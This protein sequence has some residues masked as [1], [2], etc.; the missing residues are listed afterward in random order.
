MKIAAVVGLTTAL[1]MA[2]APAASAAPALPDFDAFP[3]ADA[4]DYEV[5]GGPVYSVRGFRTPSGIYCTSSSHRG[6]SALDC[7]GPFV[8]APDDANTAHF[9][10][11]FDGAPSLAF[12]K[13]ELNTDPPKFEGHPI[14]MLQPNVT[15]AFDSADCAYTD[16]LLLSCVMDQGPHQKGFIATPTETVTIGI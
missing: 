5:R 1:F 15:Y 13:A 9:F 12:K 11:Y 16:G 10:G 3:K 6:M 14:P 2:A 7:Y 4:H 8:G